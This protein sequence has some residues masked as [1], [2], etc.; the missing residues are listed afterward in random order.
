MTDATPPLQPPVGPVGLGL[1][2]R[3]LITL[4]AASITIAGMAAA[5]EIIGPIVLSIVLVIIAHPVRAILERRGWARWAATT[6]VIVVVYLILLALGV[7]LVTALA[8]FARLVSESADAFKAQ[9]TAL[10]DWIGTLGLSSSQTEA[11]TGAVDP[12]AFFGVALSLAESTLSSLTVVVLVFAYPLFMAADA[13]YIAPLFARF[14]DSHAHVIAALAGYAHGVRQYMIVNAIFGLIVAVLDG[15]ILWALGIP[16]AFI[17]AVLAF[18]TNFIPN[19]GFVI[20]VIPP[21]VMAL[22]TGG[23]GLALIVLA[24]YCIVN[25]TLQVLVQPRFVAVAVSL[26]FTITFAS[27]IFWSF[28]LGP[29]GALLAVPLTLLLKLLLLDADPRGTWARSLSGD[30]T[31][32]E[33]PRE[34][35]SEDA[36]SPLPESHPAA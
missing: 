5:K 15:L 26:G 24:V 18:I 36:E 1:A 7:L 27:V 17:W 35:E 6:A 34:P 20:G 32:E 22:V 11:L 19:I 30:R 2:T 29:L 8:Q 33:E 21:A 12:S 28:V 16:G 31:P 25:V 3:V 13:A 14:R 9:A 23:W 10:T 4:A